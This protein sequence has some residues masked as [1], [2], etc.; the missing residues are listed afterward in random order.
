MNSAVMNNTAPVIGEKSASAWTV[1]QIEALF[2]L[3]FSDLMYQRRPSTA[4]TSTPT[5]C[6]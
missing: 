1:S 5:P 6:R 3:P 2:E 4:P